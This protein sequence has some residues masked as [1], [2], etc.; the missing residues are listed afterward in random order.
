MN[1]S[2]RKLLLAVVGTGVIGSVWYLNSL[3][4]RQAAPNEAR[5]LVSSRVMPMDAEQK[6]QRYKRAKELVRPAGFINTPGITLADL[7][8]KKVILVDFWTYSCINCQRT[9]PYLNAW[10][11]KYKAVGLEIV[12]VHTPEFQ[13]EKKYENV[14]RA[15]EQFQIRYPVVLDN[16]YATWSAYSNRY[17]PHKY[18]IDIDGFI[19]Y[20]HIGEGGYEETE[21]KIQELLKERIIALNME[22]EVAT[23]VAQPAGAVAVDFSRVK[24]PE[25][26]FG[27]ARNTTRV[28]V[29]AEPDA[30]K[31]NTLYLAGKWAFS[32]EFAES[33]S[34]EASIVFRYQAQNVY[35]VASADHD[36][37][38]EVFKDGVSQGEQTVR[39]EQL[40]Q[41]IAGE[42]YGEHTLKIEVKS[43]G[44]RAFTFT[45]G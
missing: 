24:S 38:I 25:I 33:T 10:Y 32:G 6:A 31:T 43:P 4:P 9:T 42:T 7:I 41:L 14:A 12:G 15:V 13:F 5:E 26:Y 8:G 1:E 35:M 37:R 44:L 45:F 21:E 29:A 40:Y 2:V 18:L 39:G 30:P 28:Q 19:V 36:V 27:T 20:D 17:W 23:G 34:A 16:D 3:K 22:G 11:E